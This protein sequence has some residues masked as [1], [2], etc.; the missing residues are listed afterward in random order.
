MD[1]AL[2][3]AARLAI[4]AVGVAGMTAIVITTAHNGGGRRWLPAAA[5]CALLLG[6]ASEDL[7]LL[8]LPLTT[9]EE[10]SAVWFVAFPLLVATFPSG[11]F[12]PRWSAWFVAASGI[13]LAADRLLGVIPDG[14]WG[15]F[16]TVQGAVGIACLAYR[17][18]RS[19]TTPERESVRWLLLGVMLTAA[20]FAFIQIADGVIGGPA[21]FAEVKTA[22]AILPLMFGLT[23]GVVRPRLWNID[24]VFRGA[25]VV[26]ISAA[27]LWAVARGMRATG[28]GWPWVVAAVGVAGY[29]VVRVAVR[30]ATWLVY[31]SR[32]APDEAVAQL[33]T[34][35]DADD[36]RSAAQRVADVA[37]EATGS[38]SLRLRAVAAADSVVFDARAGRDHCEDAELSETFP[39]AFR[40]EL[41]ATLCA[42]PRAGES[43]LTARDRATL[44]AIAQH[45]APALHGARALREATEA[46]AALVGMAAEERRR[47]RRELHDDLGPALLG[48]ALSAAALERRAAS[49]APSLVLELG[50]LHHDIQATAERSREISHG[51]RP[52]VLDDRG[53]EA[54]IRDRIGAGEHPRIEYQFEGLGI[55]PAAVDI[56][57]LRIV[58]EA[59]TNV[60][61]HAGATVCRVAVIRR[62]GVLAV[63][64]DDD[65]AGMPPT[66]RPGVGL[67]S[68]RERVA[69]L[70]GSAVVAVS[71]LG[72]VSVRARLPLAEGE[73]V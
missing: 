49:A 35:L 34:T 10:L 64:V 22:A 45:A 6:L 5:A 24:A 53:L 52:A 47:L 12:V 38:P 16:A 14:P 13:M 3:L 59:V 43:S 7:V 70:G 28:A 62:P 71:P 61:R 65:G 8:G 37:A 36:P 54:A 15:A 17:Y 69:E 4:P 40:G 67:R 1:E 72:G 31:R 33:A 46:Q 39:L 48:L 19:A 2:L 26:L 60:R 50:E 63:D 30:A 18:R 41:L 9:V 55:L 73:Q 66:V 27:A 58:Q 68:I 57:A 11:V 51:L 42:V 25:L 23:I 56:A 32:L 21:P 44:A 29:L 20:S